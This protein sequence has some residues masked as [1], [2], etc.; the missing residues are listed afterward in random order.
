MKVYSNPLAQMNMKTCNIKSDRRG[1]AAFTLIELLVVIAIIAILAGLL[2]PALSK[3]KQRGLATQCLNNLRQCGMATTLYANDNDDVFVPVQ[4][5]QTYWTTL[6]QP[7]V[8][9]SAKTNT[10]VLDNSSVIWGCPI[11]TQNPTNNV[12]AT[13][14]FQM[15]GFGLNLIPNSS[16]ATGS[17]AFNGDQWGPYLPVKLTNIK[18]PSSR[19]MIADSAAYYIWANS[20]NNPSFTRHNNRGNVVFFDGHLQALDVNQEYNA[21]Y[22]PS[23]PT[24]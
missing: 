15:T 6:L 2:L 24:F 4:L 21:Y 7:Y 12:A 17:G 18:Y 9:N 23:N 5:G 8:N 1:P 3:A 22:D 20:T 10:I 11:Y 19:P 14:T 16:W 13:T